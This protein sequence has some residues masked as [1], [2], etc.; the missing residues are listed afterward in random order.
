MPEVACDAFRRRIEP[1]TTLF[2]AFRDDLSAL[3]SRVL[4]KTASYNTSNLSVDHVLLLLFI[5]LQNMYFHI[6]C[7]SVD[8]ADSSND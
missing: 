3:T 4:K 5:C 7:Y 8:S 2:S 1:K 6:F